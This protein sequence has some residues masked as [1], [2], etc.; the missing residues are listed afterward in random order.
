[1]SKQPASTLICHEWLA[2]HGGSENVF[3]QLRLAIPGARAQC[4]WN[5]APARFGSEVAETWLSR[6]PLRRSK[7]ASLAFHDLAFRSVDLEG[8]SRLI[9]SSHAFGHHLAYRAARMG[10]E[11]FVYVHTPARYIWA[12]EL[13]PRGRNIAARTVSP[14]LRSWDRRHVRDTISYVAN[15]EYVRRRVKASWAVDSEVIYPPVAVRR[16]Q[17]R[18][19]KGK[20]TDSEADMIDSLPNEFVM[21]ASR[22]VSYKRLDMAIKVGSLLKLPVVIAGDGPEKERLSNY[23]GSVDVDVRLVGRVSDPVLYELYDRAVLFVFMPVEDF[24]IM[25]VEAMALGT[26]VLANSLGGASESVSATRGGT[27]VSEYAKDS[28]LRR[29]AEDAIGRAGSSIASR[30]KE[31]DESEFRTRVDGWLDGTDTR[32]RI[33]P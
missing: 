14:I 18:T 2:P 33:A 16:V 30:A 7:A 1:M 20:F 23:A 29:A 13:D 21:G 22:L 10:I 26:P 8:I 12:P 9:S 31:F 5:D 15:S 25:P 11:S 32:K 4:L 28:E 3:E 17:S 24:G 27:V 19:W 6:T